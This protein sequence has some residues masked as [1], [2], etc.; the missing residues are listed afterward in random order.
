MDRLSHLFLLTAIFSM[1]N[2]PGFLFGQQTQESPAEASKNIFDVSGQSQAAVNL[3]GNL[4]GREEIEAAKR[5]FESKLLGLKLQMDV[6]ETEHL[7]VFADLGEEETK[8]IAELSEEALLASC[9]LLKIDNPK[10]LFSTKLVVLVLEKDRFFE[11]LQRAVFETSLTASRNVLWR[12]DGDRPCV[13]V[14]TLPSPE[15]RTPGFSE[16]W[17]Q[18]TARFMGTVVLLRHFPADATHSRLPVWIRN[19]FGLY[20]SLLAQDDRELTQVYR[21]LFRQRL[22]ERTKMFD[23]SSGPEEFYNFHVAS[24]VEY[25]FSYHDP[26]RFEPMIEAL[27]KQR[28]VR[29]ERLGVDVMMEFGWDR[30]E[31]EREWRFFSIT[32]KRLAR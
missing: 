12:V 9:T 8:G 14:S 31:I 21:K 29:D 15:F 13:L 4:W 3:V 1:V 24:L 2:T 28:V 26:S 32:G 7:I 11:P 19:G 22:T 18:Y 30:N 6:A 5:H 16:N 27:R 17:R 23:F 20:A 10:T 25:L